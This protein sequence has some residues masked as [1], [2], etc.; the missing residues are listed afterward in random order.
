MRSRRVDVSSGSFEKAL[1]LA[2]AVFAD[3]EVEVSNRRWFVSPSEIRRISA[4]RIATKFAKVARQAHG[5]NQ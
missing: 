5:G 4:R 2:R 3:T 1:R